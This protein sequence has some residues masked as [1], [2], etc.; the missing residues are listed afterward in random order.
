MQAIKGQKRYR[1][2]KLIIIIIAAMGVL[3]AVALY[4]GLINRASNLSYQGNNTYNS[5][6]ERSFGSSGYNDID[7]SVA[8]SIIKKQYQT[9]FSESEDLYGPLNVE[10]LYRV[11]EGNYLWTFYKYNLGTEI[12]QMTALEFYNKNNKYY[13]YGS[14]TLA[15]DETSFTASKYSA[16]ETIKADIAQSLF[17]RIKV[18]GIVYPVWGVTENIGIINASINGNQA[19]YVREITGSDGQ[20]Y[21]F[22]L[23]KNI[24][25]IENVE[26]IE[27]IPIEGL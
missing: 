11:K 22:W 13:Y 15:F 9:T 6:Y 21:Y 14:T 8:E 10:E 1:N 18:K 5:F 7:G 23:I 24:G 2:I 26:D 25:E 16:A 19:D 3:L 20:T 17:G 4:S 27:S 12:T